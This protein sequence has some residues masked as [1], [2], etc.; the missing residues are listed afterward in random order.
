MYFKLDSKF[1]DE[2]VYRLTDEPIAMIRKALGQTYNVQNLG[3]MDWRE[4]ASS[5][6]YAAFLRLD[7]KEQLT[8]IGQGGFID[9]NLGHGLNPHNGVLL[10]LIETGIIGL[11]LYC[12]IVLGSLAQAIK[13]RNISP[14]FAVIAFIII[15]GIGQN[16]EMTSLTMFLFVGCLL[17]ENQFLSL[18]KAN[19]ET[20]WRNNEEYPADQT[21]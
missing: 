9:R 13:F 2:V 5:D 15:Y 11:I 4:E 12:L 3:S 6:A 18:N 10:I 17:A 21:A 19:P 7:F 16:E 8:G 1:V 14:S 20:P